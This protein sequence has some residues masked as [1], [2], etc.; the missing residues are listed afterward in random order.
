VR[1][2]DNESAFVR[3]MPTLCASPLLATQVLSS[4]TGKWINTTI[5]LG[6]GSP[7]LSVV[8]TPI[9]TGTYSQVR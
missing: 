7:S 8:V 2:G 5:A 1:S 9:A 3:G 4:V 6:P